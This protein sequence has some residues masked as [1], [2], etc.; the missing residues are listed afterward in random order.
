[1][2]RRTEDSRTFVAEDDT[3]QTVFYGAPVNYQ[4]ANGAWQPLDNALVPSAAPGGSLRNAAGAVE[5]SLPAVLGAA[6]VRVA[7]GDLEVSFS[8]RNSQGTTPSLGPSAKLPTPATDAAAKATATYPG[9]LSGVDVVYTATSRGV[10]EDI[11]LSGPQAPS[12]F[13]FTVTTSPGL[14]AQEGAGG[15]SFVDAEGHER[16]RFVP[17]FAYDASFEASPSAASFTEDAVSLRIVETSPELVVR[18]AADPAWLGAPERAWPVVIDPVLTIEGATADTYLRQGGPDTNYGSSTRLLLSSGTGTRRILH[19]KTIEDFFAEPVT[20][21][22][23]TLRLY[24]TTDTT[25]STVGPVGAYPLATPGWNSHQA[26]WNDRLTGV[27]WNSPG[28]DFDPQPV[29]VTDNATGPVG[30][31]S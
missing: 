1:M 11:V 4:D 14:V 20:L 25:G 22:S 10:K 7:K 15:I 30:W 26:T 31:R 19:A 9:A 5:V 28:A 8:L 23:A 17:P 12:N 24:A 3:F 2:E 6:P 29:F 16:A 27:R 13:D 21:F 18:L